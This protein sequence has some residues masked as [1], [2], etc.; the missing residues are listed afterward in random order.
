VIT[1]D[2]LKVCGCKKYYVLL[3][4]CYVMEFF[5]RYAQQKNTDADTEFD[6]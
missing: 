1:G 2:F 5:S 3:Y 6:C 4:D